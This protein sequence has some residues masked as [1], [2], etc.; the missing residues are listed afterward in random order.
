MTDILNTLKAYGVAAVTQLSAEQLPA[1]AEQL[2]A[3]GAV[4]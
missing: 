4:I 2:V 3:L 1:F